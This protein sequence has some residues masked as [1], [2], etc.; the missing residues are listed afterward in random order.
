L[1]SLLVPAE[2]R[3]EEV[4][5]KMKQLYLFDGYNV[6]NKI[7]ELKPFFPKDLPQA[8]EALTDYIAA[9]R[10]RLCPGSE[11]KIVFDAR[12]GNPDLVR[13]QTIKGLKLLFAEPGQ[14]ADDLIIS[15]VRHKHQS[16]NIMVITDDNRI[17]NNIRIYQATWLS[18]NQYVS[19]VNKVK[20]NH[21]R[22]QPLAQHK[23]G[24]IDGDDITDELRKFWLK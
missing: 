12:K 9:R 10:S 3:G 2:K 24:S 22:I 8:R 15:E 23:I 4:P 17:G 5:L 14:E 16:Q 13:Q 11:V 7:P 1:F 18:V 19:L 21:G 20:K 6:I